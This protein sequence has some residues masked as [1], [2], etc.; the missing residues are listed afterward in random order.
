MAL[1]G[2]TGGAA[3]LNQIVNPTEG[4]GKATG[5]GG[6][7]KADSSPGSAAGADFRQALS[8]AFS[9]QPSVKPGITKADLGSIK[10][11]MPTGVTPSTLKFSNHS[12]ERMHS[13]G[14]TYSP[15]QMKS[16]ENAVAKAAAKGSKDTLVLTDSSALIVSVK[17]GT[18]VTVMDRAAMKENVF[19]NIDSTVMA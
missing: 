11:Q 9:T 17:N 14:I 2:A 8:D 19:T 7:G 12:L 18:V 13:R 1:T 16:I 4:L 6:L 5:T 15:D 3:G 10:A